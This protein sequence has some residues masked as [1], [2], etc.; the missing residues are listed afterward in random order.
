MALFKLLNVLNCSVVCDPLCLYCNSPVRPSPLD[1]V[2]RCPSKQPSSPHTRNK[3]WHLSLGPEDAAEL[4]AAV[5]EH[6]LGTHTQTGTVS[7][8]HRRAENA[9][10]LTLKL[11]QAAVP[12][13][14]F[15][16]GADSRGKGGQRGLARAFGRPGDGWGRR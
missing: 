9:F 8:P 14:H 1:S 7:S 16:S 11:E 6:T 4:S 2:P 10:R 3:T 15:Q 13:L 5:Q 12:V